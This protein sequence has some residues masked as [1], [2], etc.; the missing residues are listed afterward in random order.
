MKFPNLSYARP[1]TLADAFRLLSD[2][3]DSRPLAGGQSLLPMMA[4]RVASP[5]LLV[6]LQSLEDLM[7]IE[8]T[9]DG[10]RIG[11]MVT[12][13]R[14][15]R[16]DLIRRRTPL[17]F[18]A[19]GHVAHQAIRNR[20]TIGGS[21]AHADGAAEMPLVV[22][23]LD[24]VMVIQGLQGT[25]DVPASEFF[26]GFYS[27]AVRQGELLTHIVIPDNRMSWAFEEVARRP[28]DFALAM[29]AVGLEMNGAVCTDATI[30]VGGV[31]DRPVRADAACD[32]LLGKSLDRATARAAASMALDGIRVR[33][34]VHAKGDY[35]TKLVQELVARAL[36]RAGGIDD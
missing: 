19:L 32:Y 21:I 17:L 10:L 7:A 16:S 28:G 3:E 14:N 36:S 26:E 13:D 6:D 5:G 9:D 1:N 29:V 8:E 25:R 4:L 20:G 34:D 27:T 31:S 12:H 22:L 18:E 33:S 23:A 2:N 24:A 15:S 30:V 35:R 11:A